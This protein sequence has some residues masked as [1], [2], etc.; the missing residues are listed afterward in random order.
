ML[1]RGNQ[2]RREELGAELAVMKA[3]PPT[4]LSEYD[5]VPCMVGSAST[6]RVKKVGCSVPARLIGQELKV[7][8]SERELKL[9]SGRELRL[10]LPRHCGDRGVEAGLSARNRSPVAQARG[11]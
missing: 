2:G 6:I 4:R 10:S 11:F 5:E 9:Y 3:L 7:E 1:E 8:V